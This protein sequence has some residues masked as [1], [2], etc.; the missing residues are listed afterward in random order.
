MTIGQFLKNPMPVVIDWVRPNLSQF[1]GSRQHIVWLLA[2]FIGVA[3]AFA[4]I[5]FREAIGLV[6]ALGFAIG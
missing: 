6:Q 4:A 2:L 1:T 3:T 5:L